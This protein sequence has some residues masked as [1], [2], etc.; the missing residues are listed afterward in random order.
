MAKR[1]VVFQSRQ[2]VR[3]VLPAAIRPARTLWH[4]LIGFL[5]IALAVWPI[6][7]AVRT[8]RGYN[9]DTGSTIKLVLIF[10][11][12]VLMGGYGISSFLRARKISRS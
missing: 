2:F 11:F 12:V 10:V 4:E 9:G 8:L 1:S 7:S 6:P 3:H 5:F